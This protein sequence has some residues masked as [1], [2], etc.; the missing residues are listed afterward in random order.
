M[1]SALLKG[2]SD[3]RESPTYKSEHSFLPPNRSTWQAINAAVAS[4]DLH[5]T[6]CA[7]YTEILR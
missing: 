1:D 4:L 5:Y 6:A 2:L 3:F 7:F